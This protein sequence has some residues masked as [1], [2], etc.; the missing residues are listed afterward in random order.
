MIFQHWQKFFTLNIPHAADF[1][2]GNLTGLQILC[3]AKAKTSSVP[4]NIIQVLLDN[5][6]SVASVEVPFI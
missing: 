2:H 4:D 1:L 3:V 5:V 6:Y